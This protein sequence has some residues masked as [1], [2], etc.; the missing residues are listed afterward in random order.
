MRRE[1]RNGFA[2]VGVSIG[3][4]EAKDSRRPAGWTS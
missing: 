1:E 4:P 3:E 2:L